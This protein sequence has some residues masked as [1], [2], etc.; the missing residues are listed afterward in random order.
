M[1]SARRNSLL[2]YF[3]FFTYCLLYALAHFPGLEIHTGYIG[4]AFKILHPDSFVGALTGDSHPAR[5]SLHTLLLKLGGDAWLD[6]RV[7]WVAFFAIVIFSLWGIDKIVR[8]LGVQSYLG[9]FVVLAIVLASHKFIDEE[10]RI[11]DLASIRPTT[12]CKPLVIWLTYFLLKNDNLKRILLFASL[13]CL[14][15]VKTG[16]FMFLATIIILAREFFRLRWSVILSSLL[17]FLTLIVLGNYLWNYYHGTLYQNIWLYDFI[18]NHIEN[19]E[20]NPFMDGAGPFLFVLFLSGGLLVLSSYQEPN[21][22][23]IRMIF[24]LSLVTYLLGGIY[25]TFSPDW[26][27]VSLFVPLAVTR[28]TWWTLGLLFLV[29]ASAMVRRFDDLS[30]KKQILFGLFLVLLYQFPFFNH[31]SFKSFFQNYSLVMDPLMF[32]RF[33]TIFSLV[34]AMIVVKVVY[35][36]LHM[37]YVFFIPLVVSMFLSV[38]HKLIERRDDLAFLFSKGILGGTAGAKWIDV[39]EFIRYE[40]PYD[41]KILALI[42]PNFDTDTS[43]ELRTGRTMPIGHNAA[44]FYFDYEGQQKN[45]KLQKQTA[46]LQQDWRTCIPQ[47]IS[48]DLNAFGGIDYIVIPSDYT[49]RPDVIGYQLVKEIKPFSIWKKQ[50]TI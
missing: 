31:A 18:L 40:T 39:N 41:S 11:I 32:S 29:F 10:G 17:L 38:S 9:R 8:L 26:L 24:I 45:L 7:N 4:V 16:W 27:K 23:R 12:Y 5:F 2:F 33:I 42:G 13:A 30:L 3:V 36:K 49:C 34:G 19:S 46:Q 22:K 1:D 20:A 47:D 6:D 14:T 43:L 25:Y 44:F 28:S 37:R 21:A 15:S 48:R 50:K 35:P